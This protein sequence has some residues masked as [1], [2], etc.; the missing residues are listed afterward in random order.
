MAQRLEAWLQAVW[1]DFYNPDVFCEVGLPEPHALMRAAWAAPQARR[2]RHEVT[3]PVIGFLIR[4]GALAG[5][6]AA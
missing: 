4:T 6:A 3:A 5:E 2:L 1:R